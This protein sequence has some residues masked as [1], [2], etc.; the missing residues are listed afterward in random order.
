MAVINLTTLQDILGGTIPVTATVTAI[1]SRAT[2]SLPRVAGEQIIFPQQIVVKIVKGVPEQ[3]LELTTLP[4]NYYW[5]LDVFHAGDAPYRLNVVVPAGEGPFAFSELIVVD[6]TTAI[7]DA[8]TAA[9]A[10]YS[11]LIESYALRAEAA[12][13][14]IQTLMN[15]N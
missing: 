10:A 3:V 12:L 9:A 11:A 4:P 13:A 14:E 6:P 5:E 15:G 2:R 7:P 8:G 1:A